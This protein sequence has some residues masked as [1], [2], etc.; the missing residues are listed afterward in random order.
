MRRIVASKT[1]M[2]VPKIIS[3]VKTHQFIPLQFCSR[4]WLGF[5]PGFFRLIFVFHYGE[6]AGYLAELYLLLE[7]D[8]FIGV[9]LND[10]VLTFPSCTDF[11]NHPRICCTEKLFY[12]EA[13]FLETTNFRLD[14][15]YKRKK[16][17]YNME[18]LT[19]F[20]SDCN[21]WDIFNI[22]RMMCQLSKQDVWMETEKVLI[23]IK[24]WSLT[25]L[26]AKHDRDEY[27]A[28]PYRWFYLFSEYPKQVKKKSK[29]I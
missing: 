1:S 5:R 21:V 8:H 11:S 18:T 9:I 10:K 26:Q 17:E 19:F 15:S 23:K 24:N 20:I 3:I 4:N 22:Y 16:K 27:S 25:H 29:K 12:W 13:F 2:I 28:V 6:L 7:R 14:I